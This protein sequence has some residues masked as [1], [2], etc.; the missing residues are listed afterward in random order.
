MVFAV[1]L[2]ISAMCRANENPVLVTL[3]FAENV[4]VFKEAHKR[5]DRLLKRI[6]R[7]W[8]D[9]HGVGVWQRQK[10][11]AWHLHC[12]VPHRL[13]IA[14]FRE[15]AVACGFGTFVNL[16]YIHRPGKLVNGFKQKGSSYLWTPER[17]ANYLTR[18]LTREQDNGELHAK[19]VCY[20]GKTVRKATLNFEFQG[21]MRELFLRGKQLFRELN[22]GLCNPLALRD[23]WD[24]ICRLGFESVTELGQ[25]RFLNSPS[26]R[27]WFYGDNDPLCP[28]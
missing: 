16:E 18:Y 1:K 19:V 5:W 4:V 8:P 15:M 24:F 2:A 9:L 27:R 7:R 11:G 13:A 10:R 25:E 12:V 22:P 26:V 28:F 17:V 20:W 23:N 21:T 6:R 14:V 3:T